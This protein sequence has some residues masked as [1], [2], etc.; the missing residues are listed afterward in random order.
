MLARTLA[1]A[2]YGVNGQIV[3]IECDITNGLPGVTIVGLGDKAVAESRERIRSAIRNSGH[4]IPPRRITLSLA[5]ANL[6]KDGSGYDLAMAVAILAA[7]GQVDPDVCA[8]SLF[9]GEL[10]LNGD[11]RP[12]RGTPLAQLQA[13]QVPNSAVYI[14]AANARELVH[15]HTVPCYAPTDLK[16]LVRH[17]KGDEHMPVATSNSTVQ[18]RY[19][20]EID[21]GNIVGQAA[22]KRAVE[23]A[24]AGNHSLLLWGPPGT[25]KSL[26]ARALPGLLPQ[27]SATEYQE[28][29][30]LHSDALES[31]VNGRPY[32]A[33]HHTV[34]RYQLLGSANGAR[35]GELALSHRGV[36]LLDEL[37]E[38]GRAALEAMRQ[39]LESRYVETV[40][41]GRVMRWPA[42]FLMVATMNL[43]PCGR[44]SLTS[45]CT[46]SASAVTRYLSR[47]SAPLLERIDLSAYV[48]NTETA[49]AIDPEV[50]ESS[51]TIFERVERARHLQRD[52]GYE[53]NS[54]MQLSDHKKYCKL[55]NRLHALAKALIAEH[56]LSPRGLNRLT[57][58]A[59]T[60]ADLAGHPD[61]TL[62]DFTEAAIYRPRM[63]TVTPARGD[64]QLAP[65]SSDRAHTK[66]IFRGL[67]ETRP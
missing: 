26:L 53:S 62:E 50:S 40:T 18:V 10:S 41:T 51:A 67:Q 48:P 16:S 3:S 6:R 23:I 29:R 22:A 1:I 9:L 24:A 37:P 47:V 35:P 14:P 56:N 2:A 4:R 27:P 58:V 45:M 65:D 34:T 63:E 7:T 32:R 60:I 25:G 55:D 49:L 13:A 11:I 39:P 28:I 36:I 46:C 61:I 8:S 19:P 17:L 21:M 66:A 5:P 44:R 12:V 15:G 33:P 43:C 31:L 59:R 64:I 42:T 20:A 30:R 38:F 54:G 52:R 57:Q